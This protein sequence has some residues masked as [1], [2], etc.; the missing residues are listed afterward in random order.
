MEGVA[1]GAI[2][3]ILGR[4]TIMGCPGIFATKNKQQV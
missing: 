4:N 1:T 3:D 2:Y